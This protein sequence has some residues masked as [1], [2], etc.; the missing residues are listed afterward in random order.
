MTSPVFLAG[1]KSSTPEIQ[2]NSRSRSV[3]TIRADRWITGHYMEINSATDRAVMTGSRVNGGCV[4]LRLKDTVRVKR[5]SPRAFV[6]LEL[7][8]AGNN[9]QR[10]RNSKVMHL[11][12]LSFDQRFKDVQCVLLETLCTTRRKNGAIKDIQYTAV[13]LKLWCGCLLYW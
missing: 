4:W 2:D 5:R 10:F 6:T 7:W 3:Y 1:I 12:W 8:R 9:H 13:V 11:C